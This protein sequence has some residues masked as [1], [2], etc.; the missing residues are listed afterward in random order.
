MDVPRVPPMR[1]EPPFESSGDVGDKHVPWLDDYCRACRTDLRVARKR[2][3]SVTQREAE[4]AKLY[5]AAEHITGYEYTT[6]EQIVAAGE[7]LE[8]GLTAA[9]LQALAMPESERRLMVEY[10]VDA[11]DAYITFR[12]CGLSGVELI[13]IADDGTYLYGKPNELE[14]RRGIECQRRVVR[15]TL[16]APKNRVKRRLRA[17]SCGR[18]SLT[19]GSVQ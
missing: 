3:H 9:G 18:G 14:I 15:E 16:R 7:M 13:G 6:A 8:D 17:S 12:L 19:T 1:E 4:R 11:I 2:V 10:H 5:E